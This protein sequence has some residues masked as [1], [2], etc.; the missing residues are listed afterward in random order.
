MMRLMELGP[1]LSELFPW[2][3]KTSEKGGRRAYGER[4]W[5]G[6]PLSG[7]ES[8]HSSCPASTRYV[9]W[10]PGNYSAVDFPH[11][12]RSYLEFKNK[13]QGTVCNSTSNLM[14]LCY[15]FWIIRGYLH[16]SLP[17]FTYEDQVVSLI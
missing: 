15:L 3:R 1:S 9:P 12:E 16:H 2:L 7:S 11:G 13:W 14:Q 17:C 4:A 10:P 6:A 5:G 8:K